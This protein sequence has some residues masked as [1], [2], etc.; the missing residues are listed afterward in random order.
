MGLYSTSVAYHFIQQHLFKH[1]LYFPKFVTY[2][3]IRKIHI[4]FNIT[5]YQTFACTTHLRLEHLLFIN[6]S[7]PL[8][9]PSSPTILLKSTYHHNVQEDAK[10]VVSH[11]T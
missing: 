1:N 7:L 9:L 6:P 3:Y 10:I 2:I 11:E 8:H 4:P 5:F